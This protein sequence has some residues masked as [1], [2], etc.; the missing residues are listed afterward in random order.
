MDDLMLHGLKAD[1]IQ[2][3][4]HLLVSL[5]IHGLKLSPSDRLGITEP[6]PML[7]GDLM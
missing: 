4:K 1:H 5:I 6:K 3:F 7:L 2:L